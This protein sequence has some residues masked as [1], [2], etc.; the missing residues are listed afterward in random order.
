MSKEFE[1]TGADAERYWEDRYKAG[2]PKTSGRPGVALRQFAEPLTPGRALELGCGKGDDAVWLAGQGWSVVAV[3]ISQTALDYAAANAER[4]GVAD[5]I[6]FQRHDLGQSFPEGEF[7]LVTANFLAAFP[8]DAV[9]QRAAAA[10]APGGHLLIIDHASRLPW[11]AA[12][13]SRQ[14]PTVEET[15]ATLALEE[16]D[17]TRIYSDILERQATGPDGETAMVRDTVIFLKRG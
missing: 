10:V 9:F 14:F 13:P 11:S 3:E 5:R 8:R 16:G 2:S 15:L 7:D 6:T 1:R 4:A 12:P 17:W